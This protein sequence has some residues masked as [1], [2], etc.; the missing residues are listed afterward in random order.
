MLHLFHI[1][2]MKT[3]LQLESKEK[4]EMSPKYD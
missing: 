2:P 1:I 4:Y 3:V